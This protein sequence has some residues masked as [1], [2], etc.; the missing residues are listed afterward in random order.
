LE[1]DEFRSYIGF[2]FALGEH[3]LEEVVEDQVK[4]WRNRTGLKIANEMN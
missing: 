2:L 4:L 1:Y 3:S